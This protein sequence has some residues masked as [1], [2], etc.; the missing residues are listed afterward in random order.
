MKGGGGRATKSSAIGEGVVIHL[1]GAG[2][3]RPPID[4]AW[5]TDACVACLS[6]GRRRPGADVR[7]RITEDRDSPLG[8][9]DGGEINA[10][11]GLVGNGVVVD[12]EIELT[13]PAPK[14]QRR[15]VELDPAA[16]VI[17]QDMVPANIDVICVGGEV[18]R[19]VML[20]GA[21]FAC[22][23]D[24]VAQKDDPRAARNLDSCR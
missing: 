17:S 19:L 21:G 4:D 6:I 10:I 12:R 1:N 13:E 8:R 23:V 24:G 11:A 9:I 15:R 16:G 22:V 2:A 5:R 14:R 18:D 3:R 20:A 7:D